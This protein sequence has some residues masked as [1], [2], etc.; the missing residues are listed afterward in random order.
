MADAAFDF[1]PVALQQV[2]IWE[3]SGRDALSR[4]LGFPAPEQ[5]GAIAEQNAIRAA[6]ISLRRFWIF[7]NLPLL[8][9]QPEDGAVLL[10]D[11]GRVSFKLTRGKARRV[12]PQVMAIDWDEPCAAPGRIVLSAIHRV[13][14]AVLPLA[15]GW[16][17]LIV[18]R[19]FAESIGGLLAELQAT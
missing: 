6:R 7:G 9:L 5:T 19:S 11:E 13:S 15:D 2:D 1:E 10:L 14:V 17:E 12:L 18:P 4:A 3:E 8:S 16:Y